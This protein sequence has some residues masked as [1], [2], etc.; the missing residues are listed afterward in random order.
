MLVVNDQVK[1]PVIVLPD[2]SVAPLTVAVYVI[3]ATRADEGEKVAV[4]SPANQADGGGK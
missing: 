1:G 2:R 3:P 4:E